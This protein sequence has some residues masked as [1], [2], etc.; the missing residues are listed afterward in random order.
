MLL[1]LM[2]VMQ[3]KA[4]EL[5]MIGDTSHDLQM[6]KNAGVDALAVTYGAHPEAALLASLVRC[7]QPAGP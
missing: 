7:L 2:D 3:L 1:E 6:A 5:L 4:S